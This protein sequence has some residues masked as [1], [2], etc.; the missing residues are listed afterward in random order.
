MKK[1]DVKSKTADLR[2]KANA[3]LVREVLRRSK[4]TRR[5][6]DNLLR[7]TALE[8]TVPGPRSQV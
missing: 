3:E 2:R 7:G 6:I 8:S 5:Q 4:W 1:T